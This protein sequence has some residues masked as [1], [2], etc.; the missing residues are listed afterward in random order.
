MKYRIRERER[1]G[2]WWVCDGEAAGVLQVGEIY[3]RDM[4]IYK[5]DSHVQG[6]SYFYSLNHDYTR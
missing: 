3:G 5:V 1:R 6:E 2:K 4:E